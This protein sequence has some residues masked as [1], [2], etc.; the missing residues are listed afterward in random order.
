LVTPL[1][2]QETGALERTYRDAY[3][4]PKGTLVLEVQ[5]G[6]VEVVNAEA[7]GEVVFEITQRLQRSSRAS[8]GVVQRLTRD[9]LPGGFDPERTF[10]QLKPE[11]RATGDELRLRLAD[12]RLAVFD[13]DASLQ[14]AIEVKVTVP[15]GVAIRM[16]GV[17]AGVTFPQ[18]HVG[19][20]DVESD[21]GA[22]SARRV[23]GDVRVR[24]RAAS[25][26]IGD[27]SGRSELHSDMGLV[28]AGHLRGP[29]KVSTF[30]G[31]VE[32]MQAYDALKIR[33]SD[34]LV[35]I[36]VSEP[37]PKSLDVKIAT[38]EI[39]LNVD[40]GMGL[41]LDAATTWI[42]RVKMRG[43]EPENLRGGI[44]ASSLRADLAGGGPVA[45]LRTSGGNISLVGRAPAEPF[46]MV[47]QESEPAGDAT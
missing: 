21:S 4:A 38:G 24:V 14:M 3:P 5:R 1:F 22:F 11:Y 18:D 36:G 33:G 41:S 32:V 45:R 44:N 37:A 25:I 28:L 42:G 2:A 15:R 20:L 26:K 30:N 31:S 35:Q 40:R 6:L 27:V 13:W 34:A 47:P 43:L 7:G 19:D 8:G 23:E 9:L 12:S 17:A 16:R 29:A 39:M 10:A 46:D